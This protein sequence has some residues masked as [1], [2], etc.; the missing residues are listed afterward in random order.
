[1]L[2]S[3]LLKITSGYVDGN[4]TTASSGDTMPVINPATGEEIAR[5]PV[6]GPSET[7][8][9]VESASRAVQSPPTI[10][11]R[12]EWLTQLADL[13]IAQRSELGRIITHEHGKPLPEALGEVDYSAS[14][15]R[16]YADQV[17][18][19]ALHHLPQR[20]RDHDWTVRYRPTGVV[21]LITPWNFPLAM[22]A[23]KFSAALAAGCSSVVKPSS[24]TPLSVIALFS[25]L[26][27]IGLPA[28][29][30]NLV[31]GPAA[32][33]SKVLCQH[34]AVRLIS[35]TGST[36]VGKQLLAATA[37][38][39]KR[40][41]LELGGNAPFVVFDDADLLHAV[42][43][44]VSNKFRGG[45]QTCVCANRL[46]VQTGVADQF[47]DLLVKR[48]SA[49]KIGNGMDAGVDIGP[50]ID[51]RGF[52]KVLQHVEDALNKGATRVAGHSPDIPSGDYGCF[53][54]P[55]VLRG[56]TAGMQCVH[57]ETFGPLVPVIE[58]AEEEAV[59]EAANSTEY[60]LAAYV[61][62]GDEDRA[63][64]VIARLDFGHVG[65]NTGTGPTAEAA[66]GGMKHSGFGREGGLEGLHE[67]V[68]TQ[69]VPRGG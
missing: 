5:V 19:L 32:E 51:R 27:Q 26:E 23:K 33:I 31:M 39:I 58:F 6:M 49:M 68:E 50:L 38:H 44:L 25:L 2:P 15:F 59:I 41:S 14:F 35:F 4:W 21:G 64:R 11:Q 8:R 62:T 52:D 61:F 53:F 17:Q 40:M 36:S 67:F 20:P 57:D 54:P 60:G 37:D 10:D 22:L 3:R 30:A 56:V 43:Q 63:R 48:V 47:T 69:T 9:A 55:T 42:D 24:K 66:F 46:Y 1:M 34:P 18:H 29:V 45:G 13:I 12:R 65:H 7:V 16:Y 28:G